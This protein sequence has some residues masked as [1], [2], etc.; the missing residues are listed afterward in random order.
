MDKVNETKKGRLEERLI[1]KGLRDRTKECNEGKGRNGE[2][3]SER[4]EG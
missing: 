2:R 3:G 1:R 4:G